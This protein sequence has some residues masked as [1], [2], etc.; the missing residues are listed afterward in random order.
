MQ[1]NSKH[2]ISKLGLLVW[3]CCL[4]FYLYEFFLRTFIGTLAKQIITDLSLTAELF[5]VMGAAYYVAYGLMQLPVGY[6]TDK[7]GAK[8]TIVFAFLLCSA[9]VLMF[10]FSTGFVM[11]LIARLLMGLGSSFGFVSLLVV[12]TNWFAQPLHARFIA[13]SQFIGTLGP[14]LAAGPLTNLMHGL[15]LGWRALLIRVSIV[16]FALSFLF[17]FL[18]RTKTRSHDTTDIVVLSRP[19]NII[20]QLAVL[21]KNRQAWLVAFYSALTYETID[22]L[23]STW[24]TYFLGSRNLSL[25]EAGY[26][27]SAGWLGFAIGCPLITMISEA[28]H[29]RKP[30]LVLCSLIGLFSTFFMIYVPLPAYWL[31]VA[32]FFFIGLSTSALN[33]GITMIIEHVDISVKALALGFNNGMIIIMG[34]IL[35]VGTSFFIYLPKSGPSKPQDFFV[36][37]SVLPVMYFLATILALFFIKETFCKP[38]KSLL[39]VRGREM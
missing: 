35:P 23:G 18:I 14:L 39:R 28:M 16:G 27:I 17:L 24:G 29:R 30:M 3:T 15:N 25:S 11:G 5:S 9:S 38:Q 6:L 12:I 21:F 13:L 34:A 36:G 20:S 2:K 22:Y 10:A 1:S 7:F 31:Y 26:C 33:L 37:F 8:K 32:V 19:K 4:I